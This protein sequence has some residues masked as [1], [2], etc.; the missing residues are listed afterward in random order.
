MALGERRL[1]GGGE[2]PVERKVDLE[3]HPAFERRGE[4]GRRLADQEG[5]ADARKQRRQRADAVFLGAAAGDPIDVVVA[6]DCLLGG[7]GIGRLGIVD[8]A[9]PVDGRDRLLAVR[10]AGEALDAVD[11]SGDTAT[12]RARRCIGGGGVL[13]VM[14]AGQQRCLL[15]VEHR[16]GRAVEIVDEMAAGEIDAARRHAAH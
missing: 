5:A 12:E 14:R 1:A 15:H 8:V 13:A 3:R 2:R 6:G 9:D 4:G 11:A 16:L 10:Q 7:V